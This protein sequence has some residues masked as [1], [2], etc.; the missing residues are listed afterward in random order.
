[1]RKSLIVAAA[2]LSFIAQ[3]ASA[4]TPRQVQ[5]EQQTGYQIAAVDHTRVASGTDYNA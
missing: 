4:Q 2:A 1:M 5:G 3:A